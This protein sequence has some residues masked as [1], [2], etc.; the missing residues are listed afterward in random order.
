MITSH[1]NIYY[2]IPTAITTINQGLNSFKCMI[3]VTNL[4]GLYTQLD[5]LS[6]PLVAPSFLL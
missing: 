6:V 4:T 1:L 5:I 3:K 2:F